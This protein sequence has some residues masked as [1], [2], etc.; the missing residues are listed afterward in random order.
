MATLLLAVIYIA[1]IGLGIPDSLFGAAW[2]AIYT[3]LSLPLS[4]ANFVTVLTSAGTILSSLLSARLIRRLGTGGVTALS[5]VLT[6]VALFAF[7]FSQNLVWLCACGIPLGLGAGCIDTA[8][9]NYVALHYRAT[10]MN[11]LHCFYGVGVSLSPFLMS[12][13]LSAGSWRSG[14]R[15]VGWFQAA[16]AVLTVVTLPVWSRA[17]HTSPGEA[18]SDGGQTVGFGALLRDARVRASCLAFFGSCSMEYACGSWGSTYLVQHRGLGADMAARTITLYYLG[19]TAGRFAAGLLSARWPGR[20][21]VRVGQGIVLAAIVLLLAPLPTACAGLGLFLVGFGN[22]PVFPNLLHL[23]PQ[24]FGSERSQSVMGL[25][26]AASYAGILLSPALFGILAQN[27][28][29]GLFGPYLLA[30]YALMVAGTAC[31]LRR[32]R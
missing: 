16:I 22:G 17:G 9:N 26:M 21:L 5:T 31:T 6:A 25:Q 12:L 1:F 30:F 2:P 29:T 13:A 18:V 23:T 20:R 11:F 7:S 24:L 27:F 19:I 14:Y 3:E 15:G 28:G 10:H 4:A 8:L 32:R